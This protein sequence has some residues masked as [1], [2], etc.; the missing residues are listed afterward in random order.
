MSKWVFVRG[1]AHKTRPAGRDFLFTALVETCA[2]QFGY[3]E[4]P[5]WTVTL[6]RGAGSTKL[7]SAV[8]A[9]VCAIASASDA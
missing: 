2:K 6:S 1:A 7:W 3:G 5:T 8:R 9:L 4:T